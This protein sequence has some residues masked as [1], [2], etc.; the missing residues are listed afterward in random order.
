MQIESVELVAAMIMMLSVTACGQES[1]L[2][3]A[4]NTNGER[5]Q[6]LANL[7]RLPY[8]VPIFCLFTSNS[9]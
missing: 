6:K 1:P 4:G 3:E 5:S 9:L 2:P 7:I 8:W